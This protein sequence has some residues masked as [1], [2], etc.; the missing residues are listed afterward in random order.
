MTGSIKNSVLHHRARRRAARAVAGSRLYAYY[1]EMLEKPLPAEF[2]GL[3]AELVAHEVQAEKST[4][5]PAEILQ[6][7]VP[8]PTPQS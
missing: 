8:L 4:D 1:E 7:A 3:L 5:R 2:K 6:L